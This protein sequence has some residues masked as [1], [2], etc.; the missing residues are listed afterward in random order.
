MCFCA[1]SAVQRSKVS[2]EGLTFIQKVCSTMGGVHFDSGWNR[3]SSLPLL[4]GPKWLRPLL[5]LL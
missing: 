5:C 4:S 2:G 1:S 3:F